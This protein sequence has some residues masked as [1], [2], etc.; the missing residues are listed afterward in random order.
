MNIQTIPAPKMHRSRYAGLRIEIARGD[1]LRQVY[2]LRYHA[3]RSEG[4]IPENPTGTFIDAYDYQRTSVPLAV[5]GGYGRVVG[6]IRFAVQPSGP[7]AVAGYRSSPEFETF[8]DVVP[9]LLED[10]R[11]IVS[12]ARLCIAP[13]HPARNQ[14]AMLI[15]TGL[16]AGARAVGAKWAIATARGG[17]IRFY[18]RLL[19]MTPICQPR[20]MPGLSRSYALLA[21]D[22][23]RNGARAIEH[24]PAACRT[25]FEEQAPD[26]DRQI[27]AALADMPMMEAS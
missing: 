19:H 4:I 16:V 18:Q 27:R 17:H 5:I 26:W 13:D 8:A 25:H 10:A 20:Q 14:I 9:P 1:V 12:G 7:G 23:D 3:Y 24:M 2:R 6:S 21:T 11:P 22:V 15:M